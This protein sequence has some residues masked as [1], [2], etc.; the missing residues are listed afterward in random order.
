MEEDGFLP[1]SGIQHSASVGT[2]T[3]IDTAVLIAKKKRSFC[4]A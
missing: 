3:R 1:L 2:M 4:P